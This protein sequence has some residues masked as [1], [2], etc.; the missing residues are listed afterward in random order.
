[1]EH[2]LTIRPALPEDA[3]DLLRWR[4]DP[5][6]RAMSRTSEPIP[7]ASHLAWYT[8]A[9]QDPGRLLLIGAA[10]G[11]TIGMVRF[12]HRLPGTWEISIMLAAQAR[13]RGLAKDLL[14]AGLDRLDACHR[15]VVVL[16]EVRHSNTP[17][18]RLFESLG[19]R[20]TDADQE[21]RHYRLG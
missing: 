13:G 16:A 12:D 8:A 4:N 10:A 15:G 21:F 9:C 1:M 14:A 5:L 7:E 20:L 18:I 11:E 19:F 2:P 17:S 6:V 3:F